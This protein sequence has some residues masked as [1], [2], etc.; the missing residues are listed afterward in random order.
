MSFLSNKSI[1]IFCPKFFE[2]DN[3]IK[4][5]LEKLGANVF[6][7][8]ERP[9][10]SFLAKLFIRINRNFIGF[11]TNI[12]YSKILNEIKDKNFHYVFFVN[13]ESPNDKI[14]N[15]FKNHFL[16]AKFILYMWDS[17]NNRTKSISLLPLFDLNFSF[18]PNDCNK[19][20]L[21]FRP[22]FYIDKYNFT[23][24]L[25]REYDFLFTGTAHSD[26]YILVNK[27]I[28]S[29]GK[30]TSKTHFY[31]SSKILY[32]FKKLLDSDFN[33]VKYSDISF[34]SLSHS[35][36]ALLMRKSKIIIDINHPNQLG[37][38]MRT[39]ES[40]ATKSKLIT[41]NPDVINYDFYNSD[42]IFIINRDNPKINEEFFNLPY[43]DL[44]EVYID[45]YSINGWVKD[46]FQF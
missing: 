28:N 19:F 33:N 29:I 32:L 1:L 6:L 23:N 39:F 20:N 8:D 41:T 34:N 18:D 17:F 37:L 9:S 38:S 42:N 40:M 13:P 31:L 3:E 11:F 7:Y 27:I 36:I 45:K 12:Y 10:N 2:Y 43:A 46:I 22:L 26:R 14:I 15:S 25:N 16:Q 30:S 44:N 24:N 4:K 35:E 21:I 5:T